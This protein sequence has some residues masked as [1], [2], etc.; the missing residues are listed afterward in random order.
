MVQGM[1]WN[2]DSFFILVDLK[3]SNTPSSE[4]K[5]H[6][7]QFIWPE[8]VDKTL[9]HC[10]S[11]SS[12]PDPCL[13]WFFKSTKVSTINTSLQEGYLPSHLKRPLYGPFQRNQIKQWII[14]ITMG[15]LPIFYSW[16]SWS[17]GLWLTSCRCSWRK[18]IFILFGV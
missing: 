7:F 14:L 4:I 6:Q 13:S 15:L 8:D 17:R 9:A 2:R 10:K 16:A 3:M 11:I 12:C 18:R 1:H 5:L